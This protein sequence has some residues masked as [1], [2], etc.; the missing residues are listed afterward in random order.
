MSLYMEYTKEYESP[1]S[2]WQWSGYAAIAAILRDH[3][4]KKEGDFVL[5]PN[6]YILLLATSSVHRKNKPIDVCE[7]L[8]N[9]VNNTK[10]ITGSASIQAIVEELSRV[11]T[12]QKTGKLIRS[13]A[14]IFLAQELSAALIED[15]QAI[16][17]LT[18]LYDYKPFGYTTRRISRSSAK[19]EKLTL[20]L[21]AGSN[22]AML[23][24]F[25]TG[26]AIYGGLL[27]RMFLI[28][29][30][31]FRPGNSLWSLNSSDKFLKI[32]DSLREISSLTGEIKFA[33]EAQKEY[34]LWYYPFRR[35]CEKNTDKSGILGRIHTSIIKLSILLAANDL[36][37]TVEKKHIEQS[38][39][40]G[41]KLLPNYRTFVM[42]TGYSRDNNELGSILIDL[43]ARADGNR[44]TRKKILQQPAFMIPVG[45]ELLDKLLL[46]LEGGGM[47]AQE[48]INNEIFYKLT[49]QA[50]EILQN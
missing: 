36:S 28:T 30:D 44:L 43:F 22:L 42:Q 31:E 16:K 19:V 35:S 5:M 39:A 9:H 27:A 45:A 11:E 40:E 48:K 8:I 4:Y 33:P 32:K 41:T 34:D 10:L 26:V 50:L 29:P 20:N 6:I 37:L 2:F 14:G 25:F 1:T 24:D 23:K 18:D 49:P 46:T 7:A 13:G 21:F 12:D 17:I 15:P 47:L 3:V 38:I